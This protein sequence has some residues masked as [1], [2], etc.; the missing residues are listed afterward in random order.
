VKAAYFLQ[1]GVNDEE[2]DSSEEGDNNESNELGN[3]RNNASEVK[4]KMTII[5]LISPTPTIQK[6]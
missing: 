6:K 4:I 5:Q 3:E 2:G 1:F